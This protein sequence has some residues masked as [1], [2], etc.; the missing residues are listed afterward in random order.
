VGAQANRTA[1]YRW[2]PRRVLSA[3]LAASAFV[4]VAAPAAPAAQ[5]TA[6]PAWRLSLSSQ[7]TNF[8]AGEVAEGEGAPENSY[9]QY[10]IYALN[11]GGAASSG[12]FTVTDTLPPS[13]TPSSTR[14]PTGRTIVQSPL[15]AALECSVSGQVVT[16][17]TEQEIPASMGVLIHI[18]VNVLPT[19]EGSLLNKVVVEGGGA[20]RPVE[21]AEETDVSADLPP[22]DFVG[23]DPGLAGA[24]T[25][26][27]GAA[28]NVAG[29]HPYQLTIEAGFPSREDGLVEYPVDPLRDV[30]IGLPRGMVLNPSA[31]PTRCT[32]QQLETGSI[33]SVGC[34]DAS[35]I[36]NLEVFTNLGVGPTVQRSS[37]YNMVAPP[38]TPA[39][40]G[41]EAIVGIGLFVHLRGAV[42]TEGNYVLTGSSSDLLARTANPILGFR[43][44][45]WGNP[46]E[47]DHETSRQRCTA[48]PGQTCPVSPFVRSFI[49][50]PSQCS[51]SLGL[52]GEADSWGAPGTLVTRSAELKDP[53]SSQATG[54][55]GC[56]QLSFSP[57]AEFQPETA[58]SDSPSGI[59]VKITVPQEEGIANRAPAT[60]K[61]V[62]AVLPSGLTLNSSAA[63][64]LAG[65]SER[66]IG[67]LSKA[68][69]R[70]AADP[71]SC[72]ASS[73]L[74]SVVI[75][76]PL[77][78]EP[79]QGNLYL[80]TQGS[81]PFGSLLAG[82]L[83]A[84]GQGVSIK[85]GGRFVLDPSTGRIT[86]TFDENPELPF[87][88]LKL[89][90]RGGARAPLTTPLT[91]GSFA[92]T[93][94]FEPW[95]APQ[96]PDTEARSSFT[97]S[98][99]PAASSCVSNEAELS[100][101]PGFGAGTVTPL[102]G[103]YSPFVLNLTRE[104]GSQRVQKV[105][106]VLPEGLLGKLAGVSYCSESGISE[107]ESRNAL[108][109]G[110]AERSNPSCPISS[111]VGSVDVGAG[112]GAPYN[113]HGHAYLAGSY[114]GAPLS[115]EIITPAVAGPF[116]L[117]TVA[118]RAALYVNE[119][120][121][122]IHAVSDPIPSILAGIPLDLRSIA[123][124]LNKPEFTLNPTSC[125]AMAVLGSTTSTLGQTATL[126][127]RF[128][129]GGCKGLAFKPE[130]K[131]AFTGATKRTGFPAVK[132]VLTQ[133]KGQNANLA[134]AQVVLPKGMLIAN[135]HINSPCTRVQFNSTPVPGEGCPAKSILGS[136][137][138][139]TPLLE[140]PEEGKVYFRSNGGE[141]ELPDLAVAL[142]GQIPL[143][144]VGFIDS[145]GKKGTEVRRVRTRFQGL[146]DAPV[147][148]F[149]L[150]LS[151]GKKGLLQNSKN[152]CKVSDKAN[153]ALT[154]QNGAVH[155][156][157]PKVQV[158]CGKGGG[159]KKKGG[160]S[161][162]K[163]GI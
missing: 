14:P 158:K 40:F 119:S 3:I 29:S 73:K 20:S 80:A 136:A 161:T 140:K 111:E 134:G 30:R 129:V 149:E 137:K 93:T 101:R 86:A 17:T 156:T 126:Q 141:R 78:P 55:E 12:S 19:A 107:A 1:R 118:V 2:L 47:E 6:V 104:D 160:K 155:D 54:V 109:E 125:N 121:A 76:T 117:G 154:G 22:F 81:N 26:P 61:K 70:F 67:V 37:L 64:G 50:M 68:P 127:S 82:Y 46:S 69:L 7:P 63:D 88:E 59:D 25:K 62:V 145:V 135:A 108:G 5:S 157:E 142:R 89:H 77:L 23:G 92:T 98:S 79:L 87:S 95:S 57:S 143:Q 43:V 52:Q 48:N 115:L 16:C 45:L 15:Q 65:C 36:G 131:L 38:G 24:V 51:S 10:T 150:K 116:D 152:L 72:P 94:Q 124:N 130:L 102:A 53:V 148:R 100:N 99:G 138:V 11:I 71:S 42:D 128:Q 32:E 96:A 106:A 103:T 151:G 35:Q 120:T 8:N 85:L 74:G 144:L 163:G 49:T 41:A 91:C 39:E 114:K 28:E 44:Q 159:A 153:F 123:L 60:L 83:A 162:A 105:D 84:E 27:D 112:S 9:P 75:D 18:P 113:V 139:W 58:A 97:I 147:S 34:P 21:A 31:T 4:I 13:V 110:E 56:G 132:A 133:P 90:I 33:T 146:P 122:Q 66:Q